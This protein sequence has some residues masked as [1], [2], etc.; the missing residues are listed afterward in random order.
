MGRKKVK[1][2]KFIKNV[3]ALCDLVNDKYGLKP[4]SVG[5]IE[6][7]SDMCEN[8]IIQLCNQYGGSRQLLYGDDKVLIKY[9]ENILDDRIILNFWIVN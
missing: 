6:H 3:D 9:L 4:N 5:S 1:P 2:K 7:Y 8:S